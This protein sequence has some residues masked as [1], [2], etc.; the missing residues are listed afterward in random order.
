MSV[1]G[2]GG[3]KKHKFLRS[4]TCDRIPLTP[5]LSQGQVTKVDNKVGSDMQGVTKKGEDVDFFFVMVIPLPD[6]EGERKVN[7]DIMFYLKLCN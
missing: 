6:T 7:Y 3:K 5:Q 2:G 1:A 4:L